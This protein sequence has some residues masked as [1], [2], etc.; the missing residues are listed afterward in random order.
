MEYAVEAVNLIK[1]FGENFAVSGINLKV[2]QGET[3]GLVGPDGAGKT[4]TFRILSTAMVQTSGEARI[5][6]YDVSTDEE[7]IR[8][9]IGYM[10]QHFS[11]YEDLT[12]EEN[13][14]FFADLYGIAVEFKEKRKRE[15]LRFTRLDPFL[16]R[17]VCHLSGGMQKK[18]ALA[19]CLIFTPEVLFLDEP[20]TG[21][22]PISRRELWKI[23]QSLPYL[24]ILIATPYMDEA[25][26]CDRVAL[27]REGKILIC[28][29]PLAIKQK[30]A[31]LNL[32]EA[33]VKLVE[34]AR[35]PV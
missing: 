22:D 34:E 5:L 27:M 24:T 33:F 20:T 15:L 17:R 18:L 19:C 3:F 12:V 25:E 23:L 2:R 32:E 9:K 16:N 35:T 7:K 29:T 10:P 6:G 8:A 26:R 30:T 28:D 1:K 4:T 31:S 14:D 21:V 11:L 13:L